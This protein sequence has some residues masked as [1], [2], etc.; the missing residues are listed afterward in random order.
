MDR[1][2]EQDHNALKKRSQALL[3]FLLHESADVHRACTVLAVSKTLQAG[4]QVVLPSDESSSW[5]GDSVLC[6]G[7]KFWDADVARA[8]ISNDASFLVIGYT[9]Y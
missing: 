7:I 3:R 5:Q 4:N 1:L 8:A 9:I 2:G 6:M